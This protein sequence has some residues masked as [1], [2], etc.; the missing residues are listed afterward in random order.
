MDAE[1]IINSYDE[2]QGWDDATKL[3]ICLEYI[4]N[5]KSNDIFKGFLEEHVAYDEGYGD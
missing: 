3:R 5:Q 1:A 2:S 4:E